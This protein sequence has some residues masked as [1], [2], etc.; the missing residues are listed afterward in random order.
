M[1]RCCWLLLFTLAS[2]ILYN[3]QFLRSAFD[4]NSLYY[5]DRVFATSSQ[6]FYAV[7]RTSIVNPISVK[8]PM[9][10]DFL[11]LLRSWKRH[12][13]IDL[14]DPNTL[15]MKKHRLY[16]LT[17]DFGWIAVRSLTWLDLIWFDLFWCH[18]SSC[19]YYAPYTHVN[20]HFPWKCYAFVFSFQYKR[21]I[22]WI[23]LY[24]YRI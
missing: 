18:F 4:W 13:N 22:D 1:H 24:P 11:L 14:K 3:A 23:C 12:K 20:V 6:Y 16:F 9:A 15:Y 8:W 10:I 5:R 2:Y 21:R 19:L 17:N 7:F